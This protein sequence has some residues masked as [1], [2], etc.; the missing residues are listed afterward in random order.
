MAAM[1]FDNARYQRET[2]SKPPFLFFPAE[3]QEGADER[4]IW[5]WK[6]IN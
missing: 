6:S 1:Q 3:L 5:R 2:E 4:N